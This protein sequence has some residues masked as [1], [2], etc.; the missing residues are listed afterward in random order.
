MAAGLLGIAVLGGEVVK[1]TSGQSTSA[2]VS[3][4]QTGAVHI[5]SSD[6]STQPVFLNGMDA[7]SAIEEQRLATE[8]HQ[9][10]LDS[11][12]MWNTHLQSTVLLAV[13]FCHYC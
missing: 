6:A 1:M 9:A 8:A 13:D 7:V 2:V 10:L 4:S 5:N 11:Q 12:Q 3:A